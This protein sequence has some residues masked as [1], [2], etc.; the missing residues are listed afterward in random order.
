MASIEM[1][2]PCNFFSNDPLLWNG[3]RQCVGVEGPCML[4]S[5]G[6]VFLIFNILSVHM[7][8]Q[9][10]LFMPKS[11][12][13]LLE[14]YTCPRT[15]HHLSEDI[16]CT[17]LCIYVTCCIALRLCLCICVYGHKL[18]FGEKC[19]CVRLSLNI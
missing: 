11:V 17:G 3:Q 19:L 6:N 13:V 9:V 14:K 5:Q 7:V 12:P 10:I 4:Y 8:C 2:W 1:E 18:V 16:V 15:V